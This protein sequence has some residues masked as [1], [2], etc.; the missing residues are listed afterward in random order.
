[1]MMINRIE[2][3]RM[4]T[5]CVVLRCSIIYLLTRLSCT[6]GFMT[7]QR[8]LFLCMERANAEMRNVD[9][10]IFEYEQA[11]YAT[12]FVQCRIAHVR[13]LYI[14]CQRT[15]GF[16]FDG[17]DDNST[18]GVWIVCQCPLFIFS[19]SNFIYRF[20]WARTTIR[21]LMEQQL[22]LEITRASQSW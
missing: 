21:V 22:V 9:F 18:M 1:M 6:L 5:Q 3:D 2:S 13:I 20:E 8:K 19:K 4:V 17:I 7:E 12:I 15:A 14:R 11:V 16:H 10:E